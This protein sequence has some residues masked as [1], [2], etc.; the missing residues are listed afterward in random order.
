MSVTGV[1]AAI[2]AAN[3]IIVAASTL[4]DNAGPLLEQVGFPNAA[5]REAGA[6]L[7]GGDGA[8]GSADKGS[9][10]AVGAIKGAAGQIGGAFKKL[11]KAAGGAIGRHKKRSWTQQLATPAAPFSKRR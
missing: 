6:S 9:G 5:N 11:G 7:A 10:A 3:T 1:L 2:E 4:A 8:D